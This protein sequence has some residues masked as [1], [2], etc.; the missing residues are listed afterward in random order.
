MSELFRIKPLEWRQFSTDSSYGARTP[1]GFARIYWPFGGSG[2]VLRFDWDRDA[3]YPCASLEEGK[4]I[5]E[6]YWQK[7]IKQTLVEQE[8]QVS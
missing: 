7:Y 4:Q 1:F 3:S 2:L 6:Q 8:Q 5:A